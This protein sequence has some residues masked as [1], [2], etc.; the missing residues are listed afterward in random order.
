MVSAG[1]V[2]AGAAEGPRARAGSQETPGGF[3]CHSRERAALV[4]WGPASAQTPRRRENS[5][6]GTVPPPILVTRLG[7]CP[8]TLC[9]V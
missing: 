7:H 2:G 1:P 8:G 3:A 6:H 4:T 5:G 9:S